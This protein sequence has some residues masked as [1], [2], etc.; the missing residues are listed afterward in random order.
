MCPELTSGWFED[1]VNFGK[2]GLK[3]GTG[4][5]P[6]PPCEQC[7]LFLPFFFLW[8]L[9]LISVAEMKAMILNLHTNFM[10]WDSYLAPKLSKQPPL[11][12]LLTHFLQM[13][14]LV[15]ETLCVCFFNTTVFARTIVSKWK[16][17]GIQ[18]CPY[19]T[20]GNKPFPRKLEIS[21]KRQ[22]LHKKLQWFQGGKL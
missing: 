16:W 1:P 3:K 14:W 8:K 12:H 10:G 13:C 18:G 2:F 21:K 19:L 17:L 7:P 11:V 6:P 22:S 4:V 9:P 5:D 15:G 20:I